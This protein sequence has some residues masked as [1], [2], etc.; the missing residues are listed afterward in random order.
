MFE[1]QWSVAI[2][3]KALDSAKDMGQAAV[4]LIE[5]SAVSAPAGAVGSK[6]NIVA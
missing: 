5:G 3:K 2:Q 6:L 1:A 4:Q